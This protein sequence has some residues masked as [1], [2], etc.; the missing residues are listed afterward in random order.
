MAPQIHR[1]APP[2]GI[3]NNQT[4]LKPDKTQGKTEFLPQRKL[5]ASRMTILRIF[6]LTVAAFCYW[7]SQGIQYCIDESYEYLKEKLW[8]RTVYFE[9]AIV[10]I[11]S[12]NAIKLFQLLTQ[13]GYFANY[14]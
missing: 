13:R 3:N 6:A 12:V 4:S 1:N 14:K 9:T 10:V 2:D 8:F 11:Y 5:T 7:S